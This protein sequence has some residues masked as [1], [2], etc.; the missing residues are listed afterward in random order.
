MIQNSRSAG[1]LLST[2]FKSFIK[3]IGDKYAKA[4]LCDAFGDYQLFKFGFG[5]L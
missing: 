1:I 2:T 5:V 4:I 3:I